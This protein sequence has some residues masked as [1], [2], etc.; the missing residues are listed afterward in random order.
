MTAFG[1][2]KDTEV[3]DFR[4]LESRD[5]F[6]I[7]GKTG[8]G[9]T[10][11]FDGI[12][13]A[14]YGSASGQDR[15]ETKM[16][17]SDFADDDVHTAVELEF[18]LKGKHYR[19]RRQLG[20]VKKGNKS[21]T[22]DDISFFEIV[23]DEEIPCVDRQSITEVN[24]RVEELIGLTPDQ[25]KQ[26][27]MLPQGEFR[28]LLTSDTEN[29]EA[30]LRRL[31]KTENYQ[32]LN[33]VLKTKRDEAKLAYERKLQIRNEKI[34]S[35]SSLLPPREESHLTELL[36]MDYP[37]INQI[38]AALEDEA[39]YYEEQIK[40]AEENYNK[41]NDNIKKKQKEYHEAEHLN[42][43]FL[44]LD[45]KKQQL[46]GLIARKEEFNEKQKRLSR[47]ERAA[48]LLFYE[49]NL[50][51]T[52]IEQESIHTERKKVQ[53]QFVQAEKDLKKA[54][55]VYLQ[56][57][58]RK[59]EREKTKE[60]LTELEKFLPIVTGIDATKKEMAQITA[61]GKQLKKKLDETENRLKLIDEKYQTTRKY[62]T[63][64]DAE[65]E[66]LSGSE[67]EL[68]R[69]REQAEKFTHYNK[70][71][72]EITVLEKNHAEIFPVYEKAKE[73]YR[74][75]E[76]AWLEN[77]AVVLAGHLHD[78]S[79]CPVCGSLEHPN[80]ATA[81][82]PV[83]TREELQLAKQ[84]FEEKE[85]QYQKAHVE[86]EAKK[87]QLTNSLEEIKAFTGS[88]GLDE[89]Y[90][91]LVARGKTMRSKVQAYEKAKEVRKMQ[92]EI[93]D[94]LIQEKTKL[95]PRFNKL[96]DQY[97]ELQ[98]QY[99]SKK[100]Q[101]EER[102]RNIPD[103]LT[104]LHD[105][106]KKINSVRKKKDILEN[107]WETAQ[108]QLELAKEV[109]TKA[110]ANVKH[111]KKQQDEIDAKVEKT[112][113]LFLGKLKEENFNDVA[114]YQAAKLSEEDQQ[115]MKNE[116][117]SFN[118]QLVLLTK[119]V[120][121]LKQNVKG[122]KRQDLELLQKEL[123][124]L[125]KEFENAFEELNA[126][127]DYQKQAMTRKEEIETIE[128]ELVEKEQLVS[129]VQEVY[130]MLR[131]QNAKKI[132]FERFL[133]MEYL[134]QIIYAAN[135]RLQKLSNNKYY[136]E[137]SDRQ[138]S[139][140][141]QSGL[142]L[143]VYD[144]HTGQKRDVKTLSGGEKFHAALSLALGMSDVIQSF[145]GSIQIDTMFIDEGFGSLDEEA[146]MKA[147]DALIELMETGRMIG[148]I[149]HVNELKEIFPAIL[150]VEKTKEGYSKTKF[151]VK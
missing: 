132:S 74:E 15:G 66:Q 45:E 6:V 150:E 57:E 88:E 119:Q 70:L 49:Q 114:E 54:E 65:I 81:S 14:L 145:Q 63:D 106:E 44:E 16:L 53:I 97:H 107:A 149:S 127:R 104:N 58:N 146:L 90:E 120:E 100:A 50:K 12:S 32:A 9:K 113:E 73:I 46:K 17:R 7:S 38:A 136:L 11:I 148:V 94:Q 129:S 27:V 62:L 103:D 25:F 79:P 118:Q 43:R 22:G 131:G 78:G 110:E 64:L 60:K 72:K 83:V 55:E 20:H 13:F 109:F 35:I 28:K 84:N 4:N 134:E 67:T 139:H 80:V 77:Q 108:K 34:Q 19:I 95:E 143:D 142:A 125:Q 133:Q 24:Q 98:Q 85:I 105:L 33:G 37:N 101:L 26:I 87:A 117:E 40:T 138:E 76:H 59:V 52:K 39:S 51:Q 151:I 10:T 48:K 99:I 2:Y 21:R 141:K 82:G 116:L 93:E 69:L 68:I 8:A 126:A 1:P 115:V 42:K 111:L 102:I 3:V 123:E 128:E 61:N 56:E 36:E 122:K 121:E 96:K 92:K 86:L 31:F 71:R 41:A 91:K 140:G 130:D 5:L 30:I 124:T 112:E 135:Q 29:K 144:N 137:R 75:K 23:G 47:A 18:E 89:F 147:V